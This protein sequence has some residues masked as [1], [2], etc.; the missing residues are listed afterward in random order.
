MKANKFDGPSFVN[1]NHTS[2]ALKDNSYQ[3]PIIQ[4]IIG[5]KQEP[6]RKPRG[7]NIIYL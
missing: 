4:T 7:G 2:F 1:P 5:N 6:N 3:R